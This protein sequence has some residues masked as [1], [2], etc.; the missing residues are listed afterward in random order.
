MNK[1]KRDVFVNES[2]KYVDVG[3]EHQGR[4]LLKHK[5][6][7][8]E[9]KKKFKL[10]C[11]GLVIET[12]SDTNLLQ[13]GQDLI[14]TNYSRIP[15]GSSLVS[16]LNNNCDIK[17]WE[18]LQKGD[19]L[20]MAFGG[21]A[22]HLAI[23]LGDYLNIGADYIIHSYILSR[24]VIIHRFDSQWKEKVVGIYSLKNIDN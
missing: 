18:T 6:I 12:M 11:A 21:N 3:F 2:L 13:D 20:L 5:I 16:H 22:T 23:Y 19:I 14:F 9:D 7:K 15:D 10:D 1:S 4:N 17:N 24:K 8:K